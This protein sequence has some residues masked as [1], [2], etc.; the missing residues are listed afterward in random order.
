MTDRFN[1]G[2]RVS[3]GRGVGTVYGTG[4]DTPVGHRTRVKWDEPRV[5]QPT[6]RVSRSG[7]VFTD[8][9]TEVTV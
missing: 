3:D 6:G 9:L 7:L 4:V 2:Q 5:L 8:S 1:K